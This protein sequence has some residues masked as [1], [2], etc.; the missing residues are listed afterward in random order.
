VN[1]SDV[2]SYLDQLQ[3][4][5]TLTPEGQLH[6]RAPKGVMTFVLKG[7]IKTCRVQL[8][9]LLTTGEE[10]DLPKGVTF[11]ATDYTR[12]RTWQTGKVPANGQLMTTQLPEP[13]YHD[14]P[15]AALTDKGRPCQKKKCQPTETFSNGQPASLYFRPSGLCVACWEGWEKTTQGE[16]PTDG[17]VD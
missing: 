13:T 12:F 3:V 6:Y 14:T 17:R 8:Y 2:L 5:L 7:L 16:E 4:G 10:L 9:A 11:P 15:S 1:T